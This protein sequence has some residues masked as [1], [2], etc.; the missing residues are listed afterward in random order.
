MIQIGQ[1]P[2]EGGFRNGEEQG[3]SDRGLSDEEDR[4]NNDDL[5]DGEQG[6]SEME[7]S[8]NEG[9]DSNS[10]ASIHSVHVVVDRPSK[11][12]ETFSSTNVNTYSSAS[13]SE[14]HIRG[15]PIVF[16]PHQDSSWYKLLEGYSQHMSDTTY[17]GSAILN[18][19]KKDEESRDN[20][21]AEHSTM[22]SSVAFYSN[23][24]PKSAEIK[25]GT[26]TCE[27]CRQEFTNMSTLNR[28]RMQ[29]HI[30]G[31]SKQFKCEKCESA[32]YNKTLLQ[33]HVREVHLG[34]FAHHCIVCHKG[35]PTKDRLHRHMD[36][37]HRTRWPSPC[38][39]CDQHFSHYQE[40]LDHMKEMHKYK[41]P[42]RKYNRT[43]PGKKKI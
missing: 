37:E 4:G 24:I 33:R 28:H 19:Y 43:A 41:R 22:E 10:D 16:F 39:Q 27:S 1:S 8:D 17:K 6:T 26:L 13:S 21:G 3:T 40:F 38:T 12:A 5:S 2:D 15:R 42:Q 34:V 23:L 30:E 32:F 18:P 29:K 31:R 20:V 7:L 9:E 11:K 35:F 36:S 25:K 14:K